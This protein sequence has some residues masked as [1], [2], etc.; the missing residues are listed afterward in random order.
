MTQRPRRSAKETP[1]LTTP[2]GETLYV[3]ERVIVAP[4]TGVFHQLNRS[5][6]TCGDVIGTVQSLGM[7]TAIASPFHGALVGFL[8]LE[9][10]RVR[11]GQPVAWLR[12]TARS[13]GP[14]VRPLTPPEVQPPTST[15]ITRPGGSG[16]TIGVQNAS[17]S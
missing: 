9:G 7:A 11:R 2:A 6:V 13:P 8:A 14:E 17:C 12:L 10:E 3:L 4:A 1:D 16:S 5:E 15:P